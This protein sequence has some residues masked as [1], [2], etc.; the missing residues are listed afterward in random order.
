MPLDY[1]ATAEE[2]GKNLG[3]DLAEGKP[4]LPVIYA[5]AM[6]PRPKL[7]GCARPSKRGGVDDLNQITRLIETS[8]GLEYTARM[9]GRKRNWQ[10]RRLAGYRLEIPRCPGDSGGF[11]G[12][13]NVLRRLEPDRKTVFN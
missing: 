5:L 9:A 12:R 11:R 4:T 6:H 2:L 13:A 7:P 3:D 10:S 8:G 1:K